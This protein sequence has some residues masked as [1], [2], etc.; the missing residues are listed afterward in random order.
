MSARAARMLEALPEVFRP[1]LGELLDALAASLDEAVRALSGGDLAGAAAAAHGLKGACMRFGLEELA[2]MAAQAEEC[3]R[4]GDG[5]G[6]ASALEE[7]SAVLAEL[8]A[9]AG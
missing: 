5:K 7:F 1:L 4:A 2:R 6:A 3:A 8:K 9:L